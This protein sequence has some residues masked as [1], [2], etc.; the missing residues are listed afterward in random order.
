MTK[1]NIQTALYAAI[2]IVQELN[3]ENEIRPTGDLI[4]RYSLKNFDSLCE[5]NV[6]TELEEL[7]HVEIKDNELFTD[8]EHQPIPLNAVVDKLFLIYNN[9]ENVNGEIKGK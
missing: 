1:S 8:T 2:N 9:K 7:L 5:I 6:I 4:P 3:G